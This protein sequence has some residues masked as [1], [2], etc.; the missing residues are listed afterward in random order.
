[1]AAFYRYR[2]HQR[3]LMIIFVCKQAPVKSEEMDVQEVEEPQ[4]PGEEQEVENE[5]FEV[6]QMM[7]QFTGKPMDVGIYY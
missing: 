4:E 7:L 3:L 5:E 1:M 6:N 2:Q